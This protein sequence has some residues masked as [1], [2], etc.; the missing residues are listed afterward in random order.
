M[1]TRLL[2][3]AALLVFAPAALAAYPT[4]FAAQGQPGV[5]TRDGTVRFVA[6]EAPGNRTTLAALDG[7]NGS[8]L[9]SATVPGAFGIPMLTYNGLSGG[10]AHDGTF[11]V[12]QSMGIP[13]TTQFRI[14]GTDKLTVR[15]TI[16][17]NGLFGYDALSP[18]GT[19]LYLIQRMST[20]NL[21]RY[22]VRLYDLAARKLLPGRI[23]DR[24]QE[25]WIMR[26]VATARATSGD[27]RWVYTLYR[28]PGGY[29]FV[30]A[31]DTVKA[32]AHC[33]G[34]PWPATDADQVALDSTTL[35]LTAKKLNVGAYATIDRK[36]WRVKKLS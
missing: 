26:G 1:K 28:N 18:D 32:T 19:K 13:A 23:A 5:L 16:K 9:R 11:V 2:I 30:H 20:N 6:Y 33:I 10:L 3:A 25:S 22:V 35:S 12:L 15:D 31:L 24:K 27:G 21:D 4:P 17:L 7:A 8:R 36:T 29:P 34:I 14:V